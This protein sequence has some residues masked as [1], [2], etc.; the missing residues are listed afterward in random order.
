MTSLYKEMTFQAPLEK[1]W[2]IWTAVEKTP[3]WVEGVQSSQITSIR[4]EGVGLTWKEKCYFA[5]QDIEVEHE[6]KEWVPLE[7]ATV[8]SELPLGAKIYRNIC[9]E[10]C[11]DGAKVH[12]RIHFDLGMAGMF[13][14]GD[15]MASII[16]QNL[17]STERNWIRM[18]ER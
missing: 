11:E 2:Q 16:E 12:I 17:I 10:R 5:G 14:T 9:F 1:V 15:K 7:M 6:I 8:E 3:E 18:A 4:Q 13:I